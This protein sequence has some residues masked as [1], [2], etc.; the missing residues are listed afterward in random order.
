MKPSTIFLIMAH[1]SK[2]PSIPGFTSRSSAENISETGI[3][4]PAVA[5]LQRAKP[6]TGLPDHLKSGIEC[7]SGFS[8]DD[9]RV[10]YNSDK[11]GQ[12]KA[13]A[14]A[15]GTD[16]HIGPGQEKHL[17]HEAWHVVQQKQGRVNANLQM[18]NSTPVKMELAT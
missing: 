17:P 1:T 7:M 12:L 15:Q 5:R 6:D 16:I 11:P 8:M 13:L 4:M 14:Y 3:S 10:H 2:T 9:V 18:K